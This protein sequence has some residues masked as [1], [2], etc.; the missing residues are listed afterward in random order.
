MS[1]NKKKN[2]PKDVR[3]SDEKY[4]LWLPTLFISNEICINN[5]IRKAKEIGLEVK[6][7]IVNDEFKFTLN[8]P[9][10]PRRKRFYELHDDSR[11]RLI[12]NRLMSLYK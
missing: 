1:K 6:I 3:M 4:K 5:N 8:D 12:L 2:K 9:S 11:Y 10:K 7:E